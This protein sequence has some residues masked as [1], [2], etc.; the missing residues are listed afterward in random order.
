MKSLP[1]T[2]FLKGIRNLDQF[3]AEDMADKKRHITKLQ[4]KK[5]MLQQHHGS[6]R[7]TRTKTMTCALEEHVRALGL[8]E[9]RK[10]T[11]YL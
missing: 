6:L 8:G 2:H 11:Q 7:Q 4:K 1:S 5:V 10:R 9:A 3:Y